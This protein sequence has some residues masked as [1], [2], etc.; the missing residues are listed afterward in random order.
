MRHDSNS[1][2]G[3]FT[4]IELLVVIAI[5]AVLIALLL[6]AVQ[7]AREAARRTQCKNN[8]KQFGLA[9]HNYHDVHLV[10]PP[11]AINPGMQNCNTVAGGVMNGQVRNHNGYMAILP[12][13][14][15]GNI[16]SQIDFSKPTGFAAHTTGCTPPAPVA[17]QPVLTTGERVPVF[18]CPSDPDNAPRTSTSVVY[19]YEKALR[20]SYGFVFNRVESSTGFT[21]YGQDATVDKSA[22]GMNGSARIA[23]I[24]DGTTNTLLMIETPMGKTSVE[25][26]PFWTTYA[27][28]MPIVPAY[29]INKPHPTPVGNLKV[30]AWRAGSAHAGGC[31]VLLG[32]GSGRFLSENMDQ[33]TLNALVSIK[34]GEVVGEF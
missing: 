6:P 2:R 14:E 15:L 9:L 30:Y 19:R 12:Y 32:D 28:T 25:Y 13:L 20:T 23:D 31:H 27:H 22:F 33:A 24:K 18:E 10:F 16:Y 11:A 17:W 4:L 26:G 5:I 1:K 3:G 8:L 29:G 7:Q 34:R 21:F